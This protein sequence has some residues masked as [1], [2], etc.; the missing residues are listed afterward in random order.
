MFNFVSG[1][2]SS[3]S[4]NDDSDSDDGEAFFRPMEKLIAALPSA[5]S[6][7]RSSSP[8]ILRILCSLS[9]HDETIPILA[10]RSE[11]V[12]I[13]ITCI[14]SPHVFPEVMTSILDIIHA[15][16]DLDEG[17]S[18][19]PFSDLLVRSF[20][21]RFVGPSYDDRAGEL[22][23]SEMTIVPSGSIKSELKLLCRI[24]TGVF[25]R[26][27]ITID[28]LL[29]ANLSLLLLGMIRTYTTSRRIRLHEDWLID[30]LK[31][32]QN[33]LWRVPNAYHH[34]S[35]I[36]R[37]FG[38]A[39]HSFSLFNSHTVRI[40]L[41]EVLHSLNIHPSIH[42]MIDFSYRCIREVTSEDPKL[43][44]S[45][46][47]DRFMPIFQSLS[48]EALSTTAVAYDGTHLSWDTVLGPGLEK[49]AMLLGLKSSDYVGPRHAGLYTAII[50]EALRCMY[51]AELVVRSAALA[52]LKTLITRIGSLSGCTTTLSSTTTT[53]MIIVDSS[54]PSSSSLD[55]AWLEILIS[56]LVPAI[57]RGFKQSIDS[58]KR[59]FINLFA[60]LV[61][62][63]GSTSLGAS[64]ESF[65]ADVM[66]LLHEDPEQDFFENITH[67][68]HHRRI[69]AIMKLRNLLTMKAHQ[70][71]DDDT[72]SS[73]NT[74]TLTSST[75]N[76]V[77][78][79]LSYHFLCGN[80]FS[81]K[82]HLTLMQE[83]GLF[84]G[85]ICLHL[86]WNHYF[87]TVK[88]LL[89][90]L[91]KGRVEKEKLLLSALCAVLDSFHFDIRASSPATA[92]TAL[93]DRITLIYSLGMNPED[94][95]DGGG[96]RED[97]D[98]D[99]EDGADKDGKNDDA[100]DEYD[101]DVMEQE[102]DINAEDEEKKKIV[103]VEE[104]AVVTTTTSTTVI[105]G[106]CV[107]VEE[108]VKIKIAQSLV[109]N[110]IPWIQVGKPLLL[111]TSSSSYHLSHLDSMLFIISHH[112]SSSSPSLSSLLLL[113]RSSLQ[114]TSQHHNHDPYHHQYVLTY[115]HYYQYSRST[116]LNSTLPLTPSTSLYLYCR[117]SS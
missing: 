78:I 33:L 13:L 62:S 38:P 76:H 25:Q 48:D 34:V 111:V 91:D 108:A 75:Y 39:T 26:K 12:R 89:K 49:R 46:D 40:Q 69:R 85:S 23:L 44:G 112:L 96:G 27:D 59:G 55:A 8:A 6:S 42:T 79:P 116:Q 102:E 43:I 93:Q 45:R 22:K 117:Y 67:I 88:T 113:L 115:H 5:V 71:N 90:Q 86:R 54:E 17:S 2:S 4:S 72:L 56:I 29:V 103:E 50:Y 114:S 61:R 106:P 58:V 97:K 109:N 47:F 84:L 63:I 99:E 87:S 98:E 11:I 7:C 10:R 80:E 104:E 81:K 53:T 82:D 100:V 14:A 83:A 65:H 9:Q 32:Y 74:L 73:T 37:L 64:D 77:L 94:G 110:I 52:A 41:V 68:Q 19:Y 35:F 60:H 28:P 107:D 1:S 16:L 36:N 95:G 101:G 3:S 51:D 70:Q 66:P 18:V 20:S 57:R 21:K 31:I 15:L 30:I 105:A 92:L 24:A